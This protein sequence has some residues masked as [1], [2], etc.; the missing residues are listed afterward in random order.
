VGA[1][2]KAKGKGEERSF[3]AALLRM[4]AKGG[5]ALGEGLDERDERYKFN[6]GESEL[7]ERRKTL[8][9]G[10]GFWHWGW[11]EAFA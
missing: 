3:V 11:L 6:S 8:L 9:G 4:T 1:R 10:G 2:E 5:F 7:L